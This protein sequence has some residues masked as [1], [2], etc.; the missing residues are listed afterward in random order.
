MPRICI[1]F[2][3]RIRIFDRPDTYNEL[4]SRVTDGFQIEPGN[5]LLFTW[6]YVDTMD[7][8]VIVFEVDPSAY[9]I[10]RG[11]DALNC[12]VI[13]QQSPAPD[14]IGG[15]TTGGKRPR[16]RVRQL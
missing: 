3:G 11:G 12:Y 15:W 6:E 10:I 13:E 9:D 4:V 16:S 5:V 2:N 1:L 14:A 7:S 8:S